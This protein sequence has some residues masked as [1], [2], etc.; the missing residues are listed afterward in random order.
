MSENRPLVAM[1]ALN[2]PSLPPPEA[3]AASLEATAGLVVEPGSIEVKAG[4][5]A[6]NLGKDRA[7]VA[8]VPGP[9][10]WSN[11]E[12]PCATAW[13]W[14]AATQRMQGHTAHVLVALSGETSTL[15]QRHMTLTHLTAAV[16]AHTDPAGIYW[17]G[18]RIVHDPAVFVEQANH[19]P[20]AKL[21]LH[22]WID[23]RMEENEDGSSRLFT[24]GMNA[25]GRLE[26]EIPHSRKEPAEILDFAYAIAYYTI[27][28]NS[29]IEDGH[30]VG[31][32][33]TEKIP[34]A[35]APSMWDA[36]IGVLRLEF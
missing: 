2:S 10:P 35:H 7:A 6:F 32:S 29:N 19:L 5:F 27:R 23:F 36:A 14:P 4:N 3:L 12:G 31:R 15:I 26:I 30:T 18:G 25:F 17:G 34:A 16:A 24:T 28:S 33:E 9:I 11:L 13:W 20:P 22:L 8:L 21:P 1:V